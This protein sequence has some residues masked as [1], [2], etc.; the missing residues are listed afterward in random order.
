M[1]QQ[2]TD[3]FALADRNPAYAPLYVA[4]INACRSEADEKTVKDA[5]DAA[6]SESFQIQSAGSILDTLVRRGGVVQNVYADGEPYGGT[7]EDA[8]KDEA[9]P[10]DAVVTVRYAATE[11]GCAFADAEGADKLLAE[12][13]AENP[14]EV[15]GFKAV[16]SATAA[17]GKT[18]SELQQLL[19]EKNLITKD[20]RGIERVHASYFT[21]ALQD[22]GA[23]AWNKGVWVATE[24]G[25]SAVA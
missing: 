23:L 2:H 10:E 5:I 6:R 4:A 7:L 16:L 19:K 22:A 13:F 15:E 18:T 8:Q 3:L 12:L 24:E 25:K 14:N 11:A 9:L 17:S 21:G 20:E 1:A